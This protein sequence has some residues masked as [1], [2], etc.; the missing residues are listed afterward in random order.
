MTAPADLVFQIAQVGKS[1]EAQ[2]GLDQLD[3]AQREILL[4]IGEAE[5]AG[6]APNIGPIVRGARVG[7]AL[8]TQTRLAELE[9]LGWITVQGDAGD[10]RERRLHLTQKAK[11]AF[12]Q[13]SAEI[14]KQS[15]SVAS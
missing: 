1:V 3:L 6:A 13:M 10:G 11:Q 8:T 14:A 12:A 4:F 9:E 15:S 5:S 7:T 2:S